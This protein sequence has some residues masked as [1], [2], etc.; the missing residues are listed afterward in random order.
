MKLV[1]GTTIYLQTES[2][3]VI[4]VRTDGDTTVQ[5]PGELKAFKA[6]DKVSVDGDTDAEGSITASTLTK[7]D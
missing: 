3:E 4:T 7:T 1:D 5:V 6:G 2:G